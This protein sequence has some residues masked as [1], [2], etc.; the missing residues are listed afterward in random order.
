MIFI[1][2]NYLI[3]KLNLY[4]PFLRLP[5]FKR[6]VKQMV[7]ETLPTFVAEYFTLS[8]PW[9]SN[10]QPDVFLSEG[11]NT[12]NRE[13]SIYSDEC[14]DTSNIHSRGK[15]YQDIHTSLRVFKLHENIL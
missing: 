10:K 8:E 6:E 12:T 9:R 2:I 7:L 3:L 5:K 14:K 1:V 11:G 13:S 4:S 15:R